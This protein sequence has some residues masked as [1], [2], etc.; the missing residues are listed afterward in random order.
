MRVG[1]GKAAYA[2]IETETSH[3]LPHT[4]THTHARTATHMASKFNPEEPSTTVVVVVDATN[5]N[6]QLPPEGSPTRDDDLNVRNV[7]TK[8]VAVAAPDA[9]LHALVVYDAGDRM[10]VPSDVRKAV[11]HVY[12]T[13]WDVFEELGKP[14]IQAVAFPVPAARAEAE[15]QPE[16]EGEGEVAWEPAIIRRVLGM[17]SAV[18]N[19]QVPVFTDSAHVE[20]AEQFARK[21]AATVAPCIG[22]LADRTPV[23]EDDQR[24]RYS[25]T[26]AGERAFIAPPNDDDDDLEQPK[27]FAVVVPGGVRLETLVE[28]VPDEVTAE[29]RAAQDI[30]SLNSHSPTPVFDHVVMGGTF[31]HMHPG[32]RQLLTMASLTCGTK[33]R[34]VVGVTSDAM[35]HKKKFRELIEPVEARV[36]G[37]EH[38]LATV[39]PAIEV[40][41]HVINDPGGPSV[42]DP[43]LQ[44]RSTLV[45]ELE[46][47]VVLIFFF[48]DGGCG[49]CVCVCACCFCCLE[50]HPCTCACRTPVGGASAPTILCFSSLR[51]L[52]CR[53]RLYVAGCG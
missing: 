18:R 31:D 37:V 8:A 44:V 11:S 46:A 15:G 45:K 30:V 17:G 27:V 49:V 22:H 24:R 33:G 9:T 34:L 32:H 21:A 10:S 28:V 36:K 39:N 41:V 14:L 26:K 38:F 51:P 1:I 16:G 48:F 29:M 35:L 43:L 25:V 52:L 50:T 40:E 19:P 13:C 23:F 42:V 6:R 7:L 4:R 5:S 20:L 2:L 12:M 3:T 47:H 53:P